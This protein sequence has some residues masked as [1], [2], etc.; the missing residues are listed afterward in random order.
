M[1]YFIGNIRNVLLLL[2]TW[3]ARSDGGTLACE[4]ALQST[5]ASGWEKEGELATTSPEFEYLHQKVDEKCWL[6]KMSLVTTSLSWYVFFNICLHLCSSPL[7]ADWRKSDSS[8]LQGTTGELDVEFKF[9]RHTCSLQALLP[10]PAPPPERPGE[11]A[12]RLVVLRSRLF[13]NWIVAKTNH[14]RMWSTKG[15][16]QQ[17]YQV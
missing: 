15:E 4:Q 1:W 10:F 14:C 5:L 3:E 9:Q 17:N 12:R 16:W 6:A 2:S 13:N 8:C 7:R 11:F